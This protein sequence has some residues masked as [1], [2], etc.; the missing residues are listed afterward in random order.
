MLS[1]YLPEILRANLWPLVH[2]MALKKYEHSST[3]SLR[4]K[5]TTPSYAAFRSLNLRKL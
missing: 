4:T 5:G 1:L 3:H 2:P